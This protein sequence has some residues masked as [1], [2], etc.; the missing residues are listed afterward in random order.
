MY[1]TVAQLA[2]MN[3]ATGMKL[4]LE[5]EKDP[6]AVDITD[7]IGATPLIYSTRATD[8]EAIKLLLSKGAN[9]N[10]KGFGGMTPLHHAANLMHEGTILALLEGGAD[11]NCLDAVGNTPLHFLTARG[12]LSAT[13]ILAENGA[14]IDAK[15][16]AG[17][18]PFH[19]ACNTGQ[20]QVPQKLLELN[21]DVNSQ[22]NQGNTGAHLAARGSYS[23]LIKCLLGQP[24]GKRPDLTIKN[25][26]GKTPAEYAFEEDI[27]AMLS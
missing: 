3:D 15:N 7:D 8:T 27:R 11:A 5:R 6:I 19:K 2:E 14:N 21:C 26:Q 17:S 23:N 25:K 16:S 10:H 4:L 9:V 22:D 12:L 24:D 13:L 1:V 20:L 18:T